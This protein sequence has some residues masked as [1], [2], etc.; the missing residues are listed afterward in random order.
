MKCGCTGVFLFFDDD[1]G[2]ILLLANLFSHLSSLR[3]WKF[4]SG[5]GRTRW[6][7]TAAAF[8]GRPE[9]SG[10]QLLTRVCAFL[11]V[12]RETFSHSWKKTQYKPSGHRNPSLQFYWAFDLIQRTYHLLFVSAAARDGGARRCVHARIV[13]SVSIVRAPLLFRSR[14]VAF[15]GEIGSPL[16]AQPSVQIRNLIRNSNLDN[17]RRS[18]AGC[19]WT[20]LG[21]IILFCASLSLS[22][23]FN[24]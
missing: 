3:M 10:I 22:L 19:G 23:S 12:K 17:K 4:L 1:W 6:A 5:F 11:R 20:T 8:L 21:R 13:R 7:D 16:F 9:F 14:S 15:S 24:G 2:E 18:P